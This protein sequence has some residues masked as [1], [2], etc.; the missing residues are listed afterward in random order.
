MTDMNTLRDELVARRPNDFVVVQ[1]AQSSSWTRLKSTLPN[2]NAALEKRLEQRQELVE[3]V[4][5][6]G[7]IRP[8]EGIRGSESVRPNRY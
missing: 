6:V 3:R 2:E 7:S 4:W 8:H 5:R 1:D